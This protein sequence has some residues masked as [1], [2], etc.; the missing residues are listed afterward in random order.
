M[1]YTVDAGSRASFL[2][3]FSGARYRTMI[4]VN[5]ERVCFTLNIRSDRLEAYRHLH[6][7]VWPAMQDALRTAGWTNYSLFLRGDG[8]AIGYLETLDIARSLEQMDN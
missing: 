2:E 1:A 5:V 3:T 7:A 8:L 4:G 6:E